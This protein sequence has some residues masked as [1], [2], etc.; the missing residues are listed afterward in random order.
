MVSCGHGRPLTA[1]NSVYSVA[2]SVF[3]MIRPFDVPD[4]VYDTL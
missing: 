4:F 2:D 3:Q 1:S